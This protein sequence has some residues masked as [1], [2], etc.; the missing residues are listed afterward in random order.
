[1]PSG[2]SRI[3]TVIVG[4]NEH[5]RCRKPSALCCFYRMLRLH[6]ETIRFPAHTWL[7]ASLPVSTSYYRKRLLHNH[8]PFANRCLI[9]TRGVSLQRVGA[10]L[11]RSAYRCVCIDGQGFTSTHRRRRCL[12][13]LSADSC[14]SQPSVHSESWWG[15]QHDAE[16]RPPSRV[17]T[18]TL[19]CCFTFFAASVWSG[20]ACY[21]AHSSPGGCP[22]P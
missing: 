19:Y 7:R 15:I 14:L 18:K 13:N 22:A 2:G 6:P 20:H 17:S 5:R 1:M 8:Q 11:Y 12:G 10:T 9:L 16:V 4:R 3:L 21:P